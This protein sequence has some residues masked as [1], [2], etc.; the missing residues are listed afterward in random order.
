METQPTNEAFAAAAP[1]PAPHESV[2]DKL[3]PFHH[4]APETAT[5]ETVTETQE[6][7]IAAPLAPATAPSVPTAAVTT[8]TATVTVPKEGFFK[9]VESEFEKL[10]GTKAQW[11][12]TASSVLTLVAPFVVT[13]VGMVGGQSAGTAASTILSAVQR[14]MATASTLITAVTATPTLA[15][16]LTAVQT[17]LQALLA[18]IR[19]SDPQHVQE[20]ETIVNFIVNDVASIQAALPAA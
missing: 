2:L 6:M 12:Q 3:N 19:V 11:E 13:L 10:F 1:A 7:P 4:K 14:D 15:G 16:V 9:R 18:D 8:T 5:V 20:V 17:N